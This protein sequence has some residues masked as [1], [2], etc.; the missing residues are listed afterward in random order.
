MQVIQLYSGLDI[1][2]H[3]LGATPEL[4]MALE[5]VGLHPETPP[6]VTCQ[7]RYG[8]SELISTLL[9][10]DAAL[11]LST[12]PETYNICL[13]EAMRL[14][15]VPIATAIGAH[16]DRVVDGETGILVEVD[17]A[18][19]VIQAMLR[20]QAN[21]PMLTRLAA[22]A[23]AVPLLSTHKHVDKL[24]TIYGKLPQWRGIERVEPQVPLAPQLNLEAL[25]L[26]L[27]RNRWGDSG[28]SWDEPP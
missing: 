1:D 6:I 17:N 28:V 11:F 20:L 4:H 21:R 23:S 27:S 8:R 5:N 24:E 26:R 7:G 2:L 14:G 22:A 10:L 15:V 9:Q 16:Q 18:L 19:D 12:W 13:G 3:I 25:G